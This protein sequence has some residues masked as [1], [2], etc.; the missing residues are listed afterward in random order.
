[1]EKKGEP[2][3]I[4]LKKVQRKLASPIKTKI[5]KTSLTG[6]RTTKSKKNKKKF[7]SA[8]ESAKI[9]ECLTESVF[10]GR[11]RSV[12]LGIYHTDTEGKLGQYF[13]YHNFGGSPS[14]NWREPPFS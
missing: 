14:N 4:G 8:Q 3:N 5:A 6:T 10:F 11:Y 12:F 13:R 9:L 2:V 1:M 7:G